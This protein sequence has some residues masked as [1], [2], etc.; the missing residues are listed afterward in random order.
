MN[1]RRGQAWGDQ[2]PLPTGGLSVA[3]DGEVRAAVEEAM[4]AHVDP[5]P[6]GLLG[7]DLCTTLGGRG[8]RARLATDD[9]ARVVVDV[10]HVVLD[11]L[12]EHWFVAHLVARHAWWRGRVV[13]VM[14]AAYIGSWN[15]A[16]R[17][18]PGDGLLDMLDA[19]LSLSDRG[20][21]RTRLPLGTH[22]PH[23]AIRVSR[24]RVVDFELDRLTPIWLDGER[25][26]RAH[27]VHVEV[28]P[29]AL[30]VVV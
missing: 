25:V 15:I 3:T 26:G 29:D 4:R 14:N 22:V 8:N 9:A 21:A 7:G 1:I 19:D 18:H 24:L 5:P 30:V 12:T 2:G 27:H 10:A 17:A 20:K 13:A 28:V 6:L 23:P 16:P 11:D